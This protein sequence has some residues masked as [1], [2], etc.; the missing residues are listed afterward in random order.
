[1]NA[2][3]AL[4]NS[5]SFLASSTSLINAFTVFHLYC[6]LILSVILIITQL[7]YLNFTAKN[8]Q[9]PLL[10]CEEEFCAFFD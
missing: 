4:T 6:A 9:I 1:M 3:N 10:K 2:R 8:A 7:L 5:G